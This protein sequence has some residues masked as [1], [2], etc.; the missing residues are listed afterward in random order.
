M[1]D[2]QDTI[3]PDAKEE[4]E[5]ELEEEND[6]P[7]DIQSLSN[8]EQL[9]DEITKEKKPRKKKYLKTRKTPSHQLTDNHPP[10]RFGPANP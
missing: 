7:L 2:K 4:S 9:I 10:R 3:A 8:V 1:K 5:H 6:E